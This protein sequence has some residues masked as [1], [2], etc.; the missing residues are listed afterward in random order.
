[1]KKRTVRMTAAAI[2]MTLAAAA[3]GARWQLFRALFPDETGAF[4]TTSAGERVDLTG[5]FFQSLGTNGRSCSTCHQADQ[6]MGI[7]TPQI[8][9]R[10]AQ[11]RG[12]DPLFAAVDGANCPTAAMD[13]KSAHSLLL[14]HGLIRIAITLPATAQFTVSVAHD[15]YGCALNKDPQT[16][17][18]TVSEY[19]R[20]LPTTNLRYLSTL[21]FD[22][23]E[24]PAASASSTI[25]R[26]L[27]PTC[28]PT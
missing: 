2:S 15:P 27:R 7:S 20:P 13:D 21:M 22:G 6:A 18:V 28:K 14:D 17:L 9:E 26:L 1:M 8:R 11:T 19:R 10:F 3:V 16:G 4:A 5:P 25:P 24:S 12:R 23:R